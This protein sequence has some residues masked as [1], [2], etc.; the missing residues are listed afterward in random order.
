MATS[1]S[2]DYN[3]TAIQIVNGA[4][5]LI[6][7]VSQE[8]PLQSAERED[9][10]EALNLMVKTWQNQGLHLWTKKE[11]IL[12]LDVGKTDYYL[13]ATGDEA[14]N[15][16]EFVST[17]LTSAAIATDTV[18]TVSSTAGM[19]ASDKI[20]VELD[21]GTRQ[22]TTIVSVD[23]STGLTIT[24]ALT[25]AAAASNTVYTYTTQ[26]N[27][28]LRILGA[29]RATIGETSEI[30]VR[31]FESRS[32]YF[33]QPDKTTQGTVINYY[34][35]PELNNGRI[36]IWQTADNVRKVLKF[37]YERSLEDFDANNND[38]D[39]PVEWVET[40]KYNLAARLGLEYGTSP[41][42]LDR[43]KFAAD[44]MLQNAL[45][46]DTDPLYLSIQ[47]DFS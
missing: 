6:G 33:N 31:P 35:S 25:G 36:Y 30:E 42:R 26:I 1:G 21:D 24:A 22:W 28:P 8:Q 43:I 2:V 16:D 29:R 5:R 39:F 10:M 13:G 44:E 47:P 23:S 7:V 3:R 9:G 46:Y 11:G 37:T 17:T 27:R 45:G 32:H 12:F 20:G 14:T 19:T 41:E 4:F 40:I 18:L 34:Y 15:L 38:P